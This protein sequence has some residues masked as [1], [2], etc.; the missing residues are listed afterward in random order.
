MDAVDLDAAS[1]HLQLAAQAIGLSLPSEKACPDVFAGQVTIVW[2]QWQPGDVPLQ[3]W[4]CC[5][6]DGD[7]RQILTVTKIIVHADPVNFVWAELEMFA[8][9]DGRPVRDVPDGAPLPLGE[10]GEP[11]TAVFPYLVQGMS[12][13]AP[14]I[15]ETAAAV[16]A[17]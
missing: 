5:V 9:E 17:G 10:D 12:I 16:A 8:D 13:G 11:R 15:T 7:G 2:P 14:A 3:G 6:F 4:R 1:R